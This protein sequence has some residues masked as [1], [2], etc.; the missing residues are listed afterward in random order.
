MLELAPRAKRQ[1]S[2]GTSPTPTSEQSDGS[3]SRSS[4]STPIGE[5]L[6]SDFSV[7]ELPG[8]CSSDSIQNTPGSGVSAS[9][10]DDSASVIVHTALL[11]RIEA[12]ESSNEQLSSQL[13][14]QKKYFRLEHISHDDSLVHFYTGFN[15]YELLITIFQFLGPAVNNLTYWGTKKST[16]RKKSTKLDPLNQFFVTLIKLRLNLRERDIAY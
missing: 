1:L 13:S 16:V 10:N 5:V 2:Y 6:L 7:Y 8:E 9:N 14:S 4:M 3:D 11:A 12:L 15:S